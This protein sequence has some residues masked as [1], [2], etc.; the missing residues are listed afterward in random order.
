MCVCVCEREREREFCLPFLCSC[1]FSDIETKYCYSVTEEKKKQEEKNLKG[2]LGKE[3]NTR[4]SGILHSH[5]NSVTKGQ[6]LEQVISLVSVCLA[7]E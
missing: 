2:T 4:E 7:V 3:E 6:C 1:S 5:L